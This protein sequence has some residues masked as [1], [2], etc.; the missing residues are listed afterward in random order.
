MVRI[1]DLYHLQEVD[2]EID[3]VEVALAAVRERQRDEGR[4]AEL[5]LR[6]AELE[7]SLLSVRAAQRA[8]EDDVEDARAKTQAVEAKLY[9]GSI[10]ATRELRDLQR[11]L[12]SLQRVQQGHDERALAVMTEADELNA[13]LEGTRSALAE[14]ETRLQMTRGELERQA[15]ELEEK[16]AILRADRQQE[17]KPVD[18]ASL[19]LYEQLRRIRG[20]RAVAS[21]RRGV[22]EGCR[23]MLPSNLFN[24]ARSGMTLVQC[25]SCERILYVG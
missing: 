14:E 4:L 2:L 12:E 19:A 22:C 16:L 7:G 23:I 10:S 6:I 20:G 11:D 24:R 21:V 9:G 1:A 13:S 17:A 15:A 8:A 18:A 3:A 25:S 5:R